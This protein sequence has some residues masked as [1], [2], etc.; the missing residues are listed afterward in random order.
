M[1]FA[2]VYCGG[3][4]GKANGGVT[5]AHFALKNPLKCTLSIFHMRN[6]IQTL[7]QQISPGMPIGSKRL[8]AA[9]ISNGLA[10]KYVKS[11]WLQRLD[12]GVYLFAWDVL[13]PDKALRFLEDRISGIRIAAKSALARHGYCQ[14]VAFG[15]ETI[16]WADERAVLPA[17]ARQA[18]C[19]FRFSV[20]QL[21]AA[22][23]PMGE[24]VSRLPDT[25]EGPLVSQPEWALLELLSEVGAAQSMEEAKGIMEGMER[26]RPKRLAMAMAACRM[27][28]ATR[29]CVMWAKEFG[30]PWA[31]TAQQALPDNHRKGRWTGQLSEGGTLSLPALP[32]R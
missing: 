31:D 16:V 21:F 5:F 15:G 18:P 28:K 13:D 25:P 22:E 30:F 24:R 27:V 4:G 10:A 19:R 2:D 7:R 23:V 26:I 20:R 29:L 17:W 6:R 8:Q 11:G 14:Q 12:R 3:G 9:G 32:L 1:F